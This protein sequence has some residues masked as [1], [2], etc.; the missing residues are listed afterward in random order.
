MTRAE[1]T[2]V[3]VQGVKVHLKT[4]NH[5]EEAHLQGVRYFAHSHALMYLRYLLSYEN[6]TADRGERKTFFQR[7]ASNLLCDSVLVSCLCRAFLEY[8]SLKCLGKFE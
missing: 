8:L 5:S 2:L 3:H 1:G 4:L 7:A 6:D